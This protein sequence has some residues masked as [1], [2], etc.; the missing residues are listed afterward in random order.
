M[1]PTVVKIMVRFDV[2][3]LILR[4]RLLP[5]CI[6]FV[7]AEVVAH[8]LCCLA[9]SSSLLDLFRLSPTLQLLLELLRLELHLL[10]R[11]WWVACHH[12]HLLSHL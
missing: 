5:T 11:W 4:I 12:I 9:V 2:A 3:I 8:V 6:A 1:A 7:A 10:H